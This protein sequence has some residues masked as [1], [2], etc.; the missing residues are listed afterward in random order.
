MPTTPLNRLTQ[1]TDPNSGNTYFG[2][3]AEDDLTSVKDPRSL[4][5][6]YGYNGF[7][8][9]LSQVS[10]DTGTSDEYV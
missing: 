3:D 5:T 1:I 6:S 2:Y 4:T 10:P 8:D 9:V 7:G